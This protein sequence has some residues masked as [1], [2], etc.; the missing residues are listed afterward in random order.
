MLQVF[1][2]NNFTCDFV[3]V[4]CLVLMVVLYVTFRTFEVASKHAMLK[5][6]YLLPVLGSFVPYFINQQ[7]FSI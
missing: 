6:L 3:S 1:S 7:N 4:A 5:N 2:V